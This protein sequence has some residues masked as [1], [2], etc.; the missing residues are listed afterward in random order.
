MLCCRWILKYPYKYFL[1]LSYDNYSV[2]FVIPGSNKIYRMAHYRRWSKYD[3]GFQPGY[4]NRVRWFRYDEAF[5]IDNL[6]VDETRQLRFCPGL[7]RSN[8]FRHEYAKDNAQGVIYRPDI[9]NFFKLFRKNISLL[10][11]NFKFKKFV[12]GELGTKR[13]RPHFHVVLYSKQSIGIQE[14]TALVVRVGLCRIGLDFSRTELLQIKSN[15]QTKEF[16]V[17]YRHML[18]AMIV[19]MEFHRLRGLLKNVA[20]KRY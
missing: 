12:I 14:L 7:Y 4:K 18:M 2:P 20:F 6:T 16:L 3:E 1:T 13:K 17:T 11:G 9:C 19:V 8:L 10:H 5:P 15:V